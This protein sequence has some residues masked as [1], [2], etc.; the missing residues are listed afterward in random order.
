MGCNCGKAKKQVINNVHNQE[1]LNIVEETYQRLIFGKE[2]SDITELDWIEI[3]TIW[4]LLYPNAKATPSQEGVLKDI[5]NAR[6]FRK[7]TYTK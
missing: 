3:Y 2:Q 7:I 5:I 1:I 4:R 6:Q